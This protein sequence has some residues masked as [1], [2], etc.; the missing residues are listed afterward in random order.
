MHRTG[1]PFCFMTQFW[2]ERYRDYY[3]DYC[4]PSLLAPNNLPLL[5]AKD[6][7]CFLIATPREDWDA[8]EHL[9]IIEKLRQFVTPTLVETPAPTNL[10]MQPSLGIR[11]TPSNACLRP[12]TRE[13]VTAAPF[14]RI[15]FF[16]TNLFLP[17]CAGSRLV[18]TWSCSLW[19]A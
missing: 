5:R 15:T 18:I 1:R 13:T 7:H 10:A 3:V 4:L 17:C 19:S 6:G 12:D 8:I 9:P 2:G 14:G 16:P 11:H